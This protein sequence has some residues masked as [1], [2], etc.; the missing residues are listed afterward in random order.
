LW[1]LDTSFIVDYDTLIDICRSYDRQR[2]T[3]PRNPPIAMIKLSAEIDLLPVH[4]FI[5]SYLLATKRRLPPL[6]YLAL[7]SSVEAESSTGITSKP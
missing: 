5:A 4:F 7:D 2:W 1:I 6:D 3:A